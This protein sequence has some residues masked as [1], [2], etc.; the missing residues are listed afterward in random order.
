MKPAALKDSPETAT[1]APPG[2]GEARG[3]SLPNDPQTG[4]AVAQALVDAGFLRPDQMAHARRV[5]GKLPTPRTFVRLLRDLHMV[6]DEQIRETPA[7]R[8]GS[9][10]A[11]ATC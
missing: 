6:S 4:I 5:Q 11:S 2:T 3:P 10:P 1:P 7:A 8:G 9:R